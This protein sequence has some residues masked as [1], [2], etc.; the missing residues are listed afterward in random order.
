MGKGWMPFDN[1]PKRHHASTPDQVALKVCE[2]GI[3]FLVS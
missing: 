1:T 2:T 3:F